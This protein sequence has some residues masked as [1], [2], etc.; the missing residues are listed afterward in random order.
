MN[1]QNIGERL[2]RLRLGAGLGQQELAERAQVAAG[3]ISMVERG[4]AV[5]DPRTVRALAEVL[6][7][8]P[9]YLTLPRA[10]LATTTPQLRAYA[11]ASQK[12]VDR[13]LHDTR[14]ATEAIREL[15]LQLVPDILPIFDGDT[16]DFS[17]ID[18]IAADSRTLAGLRDDEPVGNAI[19]AAERLGCVVLPM[20]SELGRHFGMSMRVDDVPVIRVS[21]SST[22]PELA[23]PG[24]RQRFT[25]A[26]ELG[27]LVLHAGLGQPLAAPDASRREDEAHR[28]AAA[29]LVPGDAALR[30]LEELGG[31]V[32]LTTL[33]RLKGKW[34]FSIKAFV[35]R[36]RQLGAIDDDHARSL[37][38]QIS[39]RRWNRTEPVVVG[40]ESAVWLARAVGGSRPLDESIAALSA[41]L[42]VGPEHFRRWVDWSPKPAPRPAG[43]VSSMPTPATPSS[44]RISEKLAPVTRMRART[45]SCS[46]T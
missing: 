14:T 17:E 43:L 13:V 20:D 21:R 45:D 25:V 26:H 4:R 35:T 39:A 42:G 31:R 7:V 34:G 32:T 6:D 38:K 41:Q 11:D 37:F 3:T 44:D 10:E 8:S 23:V 19:R 16:N 24:D 22:D 29:F 46:E 28:F 40:N 30:D 5:L 15:R 18:R 12:T 2:L 27:H 9:E 33:S 1:D 36:F